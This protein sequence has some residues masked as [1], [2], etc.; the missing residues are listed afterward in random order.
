[1]QYLFEAK[2][3]CIRAAKIVGM[4]AAVV[5]VINSSSTLS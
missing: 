5:T 1:M 3:E 2:I 4:A